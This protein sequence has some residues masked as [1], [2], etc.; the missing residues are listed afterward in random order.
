MKKDDTISFLILLK[1]NC[2]YLKITKTLFFVVI[3]QIKHN[4]FVKLFK[5]VY[6]K[7]IRFLFE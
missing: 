4:F 6:N 1:M 3:I 7:L 5:F 2:G